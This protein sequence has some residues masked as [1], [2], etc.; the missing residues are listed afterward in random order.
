MNA[1]ICKYNNVVA[2]AKK[3]KCHF[4]LFLEVSLTVKAKKIL[5]NQI[6]KKHESTSTLGIVLMNIR[7]FWVGIMYIFIY[8]VPEESC[9]FWKP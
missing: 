2:K 9:C 8:M 4:F 7:F 1:C 5:P 3:I 6:K